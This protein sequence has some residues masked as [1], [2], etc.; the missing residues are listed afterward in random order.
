MPVCTHL[1][2]VNTSQLFGSNFV[3]TSSPGSP[4][5]V[6][7]L[8]TTPLFYPLTPYSPLRVPSD[9]P[10]TPFDSLFC[11]VLPCDCLPVYEFISQMLSACHASLQ[12]Q[13]PV[14]QIGSALQQPTDN[15]LC[16]MVTD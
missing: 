9:S 10:V 4:L 5:P 7:L 14:T 15:I 2:H 6:V 11:S 13:T 1:A 12:H 8:L 16:V 3:Q